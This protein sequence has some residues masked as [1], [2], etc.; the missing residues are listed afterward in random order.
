LEA[1]LENTFFVISKLAW[2]LIAPGNLLVLLGATAWLLRLIGWKRTSR[3]LLTSLISAVLLLSFFP[4]GSWLLAPLEK[5]F[6]TNPALPVQ[7]DGIIVL[8]G[9][10]DADLSV[11]WGQVELEASAERV[12]SLFYL[13]GL[14]PQAQLIYT[15]G[16]GS[17]TRQEFRDADQAQLFFEQLGLDDRAILYERQ[18]RN[19]A[20]NAQFSRELVNP[21]PG[22]EWILV[23]SAFH[24]PRAVGVFCAQNWPATPYPVDHITTPGRL[25]H[26]G[27]SFANNLSTLEFALREWAGLLAYRLS[28]RTN[29]LLPG[30]SSQCGPD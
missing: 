20:E 12:T 8:G 11:T 2:T 23:T 30:P 26:P 17:L 14:Y 22:Q 5:R 9:A 1:L 29:T 21:R 27:F 15:G 25:L 19:T 7:A 10:I 6:P 18:S 4:V 13:A 16:S 3:F 28:G 24:I